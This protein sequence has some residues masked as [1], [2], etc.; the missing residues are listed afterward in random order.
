ME[1]DAFPEKTGVPPTEL[2]D[3]DLDRELAHLHETRH[4]VFLHG[5]TAALQNHSERTGDLE[6]EYLR[7]HP[8]REIHERGTGRE[9]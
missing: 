8:A 9:P 1:T 7:R 4:E 5:P 6:L 2:T 3:A